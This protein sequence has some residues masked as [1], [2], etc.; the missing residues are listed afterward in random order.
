MKY[1]IEKDVPVSGIPVQRS[2]YPFHDMEVGDSFVAPIA[3]RPG[4]TS[5]ARAVGE[6]KDPEWRFVTKKVNAKQIRIWRVR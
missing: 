2:I 4:L 6:R 5:S 3:K 1:H